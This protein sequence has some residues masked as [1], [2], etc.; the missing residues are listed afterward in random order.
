MLISYYLIKLW[1]GAKL[2]TYFTHLNFYYP[3]YMIKRLR[4]EI[5]F[6]FKCPELTTFLEYNKHL[7]DAWWCI[8]WMNAY[9]NKI[10][11]LLLL[12]RRGRWL[13]ILFDIHSKSS[14]AYKQAISESFLLPSYSGRKKSLK[15]LQLHF[16]GIFEKP[17]LFISRKNGLLAVVWNF[18]SPCV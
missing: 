9:T 16:W 8:D 11:S 6:I 13:P 5:D 7:I 2:F 1:I 10:E 15:Y 12:F 18:P 4:A 14:Y 17:F 3:L